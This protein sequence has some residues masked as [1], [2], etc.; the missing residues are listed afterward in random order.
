M[1]KYRSLSTESKPEL[2]HS[3]IL[4]QIDF[5]NASLYGLPNT[6]L[7]GLQMILNYAVRFFVNIPR[8]N[9]DRITQ[10]AIELHFFPLKARIDF[11]ICLLAHKSLLSREPRCNKNLLQPVSNPSLCSSTST[12]LVDPF[13]SRQ[14]TIVH[15][16]CQCAPRLHNHLPQELRTIDNLSTFK[17]ELKKM[18]SKKLMIWKNQLQQLITKPNLTTS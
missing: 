15:S 14:N 11:E 3:L 16:F 7:H 5:C 2:V 10:G 18:F 8:Y 6:D 9:T 12:K 17:E 13:F 1:K 4:T